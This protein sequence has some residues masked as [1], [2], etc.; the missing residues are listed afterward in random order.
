M[1]II[2]EGKTT[3]R[4]KSPNENEKIAVGWPLARLSPEPV[5]WASFYDDMSPFSPGSLNILYCEE[6]VQKHDVHNNYYKAIVQHQLLYICINC[7]W[8]KLM[9]KYVY[10]LLNYEDV[11]SNR[12]S[13][14]QR[15]LEDVF[16]SLNK[17]IFSFFRRCCCMSMLSVGP[18]ILFDEPTTSRPLT[19][20]F[21]QQPFVLD[22]REG[23]KSF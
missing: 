2:W 5:F 4:R 19:S 9:L 10:I 21:Q 11:N 13:F 3:C 6:L 17:Y 7:T 22:H 15:G 14:P 16:F 1:K 20:H 23:D 8:P 12:H 18:G